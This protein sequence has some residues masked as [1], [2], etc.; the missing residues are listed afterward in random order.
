MVVSRVFVHKACWMAMLTVLIALMTQVAV[1]SGAEQ[2]AQ[3]SL[4]Q[5]YD[6]LLGELEARKGEI[7]KDRA[8]LDE[9]SER[10]IEPHIDFLRMSKLVMGRYWRKM[11][12]D[13]QAYMRRKISTAMIKLYDPDKELKVEFLGARVSPKGNKSIV[14]T[15]WQA[16]DNAQIYAVDYRLRLNDAQWMVYDVSVDGISV[17]QS[18]KTA[19]SDE[20]ESTSLERYMAS[21]EDEVDVK[22]RTAAGVMK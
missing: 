3:A 12:E 18:Y 11:S 19:V 6:D 21:L 9:V 2:T 1:A 20:I 8:L 5:L 16:G 15:R 10:I 14:Q 22:R 17:L 13:E 4:E 7:L